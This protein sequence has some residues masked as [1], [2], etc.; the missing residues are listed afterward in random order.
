[1]QNVQGAFT[2]DYPHVITQDICVISFVYEEQYGWKIYKIGER[3]EYFKE[4]I[5]LKEAIKRAL[6]QL[7]E[8]KKV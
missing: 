3:E 1:M 7:K 5:S 6:V 8:N 4:T 2:I